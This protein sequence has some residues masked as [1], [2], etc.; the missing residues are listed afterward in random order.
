MKADNAEDAEDDGR[1]RSE[2]RVGVGDDED[3]AEG[4]ADQCSG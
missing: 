4:G 3:Q 1:R 2:R